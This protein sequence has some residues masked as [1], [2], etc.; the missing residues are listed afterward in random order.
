MGC[1]PNC[2]A[3]AATTMQLSDGRQDVMQGR[4]L[5]VVLHGK[6]P[7]ECLRDTDLPSRDRPR[8]S[9]SAQGYL[10]EGGTKFSPSKR[11]ADCL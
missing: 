9:K 5:Q 11:S 1:G 8:P 2:V 6:A 4:E 3:G 10:A 7:R